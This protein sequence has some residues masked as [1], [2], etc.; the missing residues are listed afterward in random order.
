MSDLEM[1]DGLSDSSSYN[2][3]HRA[4]L[5]AFLARS[6]MTTDEI[7]PLLAAIMSAHE[8]DRP[9]LVGDITPPDITNFIQQVNIRISPLDYEIRSSRSQTSRVLFYSL[10]NTTSDSLTHLATTFSHEEIAY[11]KRLLDCMFETN[12]TRSREIMAVSSMEASRLTKAP[13]ENRQSLAAANGDGEDGAQ[14]Q[15]AAA[16]KGISISES[17]KVLAQL[18]EQHFFNKSSR[19]YYS[20]APR[21]LMELRVYLKET[22]NEAGDPEYEDSEPI[23]RIKD[24]EGCR[25]IVTVGVRCSDKEC[26]VRFHEQ[27]AVLYF[28]NQRGDTQRC[29]TCKTEWGGNLFVGERAVYQG[30]RRANGTGAG[31]H[32]SS[33][34]Q[35]DDED[36]D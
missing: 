23:V 22:Y 1:G 26:R 9:L 20:L 24:C 12:N 19:G 29:P 10:V 14:S 15:A 3:A 8:P 28:R 5:Q 25:E 27:C 35:V 16:V 18:V 6:V 13:R 17:D 11:I 4:F 30:E 34:V 2:N 21:A 31:R 33:R 32:S 7:K 36:E